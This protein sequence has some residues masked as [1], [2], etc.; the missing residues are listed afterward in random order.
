MKSNWPAFVAFT[1]ALM[2]VA[3]L[4][5]QLRLTQWQTGLPAAFSTALVGGIIT[6]RPRK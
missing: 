1:V 2:A 6:Y 3:A 5:Q 4:A